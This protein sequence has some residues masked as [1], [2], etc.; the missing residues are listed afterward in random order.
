MVCKDGNKAL[1]ITN[2]HSP[3]KSEHEAERL[4]QLGVEVHGGYVGDHVAVSRAFRNVCYAAGMKWAGL[5]HEPE[6]HRL[7]IDART[8]F[9]ILGSDGIWGPLKDQ[10]AVI[11][12]RKALRTT[13]KPQDAA[14][15]FIENAAKVSAAADNAAAVVVVFKFPGPLPKRNAPLSK[16][17]VSLAA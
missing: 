17:N 8:D 4:R 3:A 13:E 14:Q 1:T 5:R 10:F 7:E 6:V 15:A 9:L 2:D 16:R 11:H 12:A